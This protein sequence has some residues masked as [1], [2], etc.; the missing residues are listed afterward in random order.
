MVKKNGVEHSPT[1]NRILAAIPLERLACCCHHLNLRK[2]S[3]GEVVIRQEET[4]KT[5]LFPTTAISGGFSAD[6]QGQQVEFSVFGNHEANGLAAVLQDDGVAHLGSCIVT[7]A[8]YCYE[9]D[10]QFLVTK[11][12]KDPEVKRIM[13]VACQRLYEQMV[14]LGQCYR[15]HQLEQSLRTRL[16]MQLDR[17]PDDLIH[18]THEMLASQM[19][20]RRERITVKFKAMQD[21]GILKSSRG[22]ITVLDRPKLEATAC[23]CYT[24][25]K[26]LYNSK[27]TS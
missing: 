11:C 22:K 21:E 7:R 25:L 24:R 19:G 26:K 17:S 6:A 10:A 12:C 14:V 4:F 9:I 20:V 18:A 27:F 1:Q 3:L 5:I 2:L 15:I 8:G 23:S 16:L 13:H